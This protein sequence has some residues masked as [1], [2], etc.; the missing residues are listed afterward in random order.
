MHA[1]L[2]KVC[3]LLAL[4]GEMSNMFFSKLEGV[5]S[6]LI[7]A[8]LIVSI[9]NTYLSPSAVNIEK[10]SLNQ[11][12]L[13]FAEMKCPRDDAVY[14]LWDTWETVIQCTTLKS[15]AVY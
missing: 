11:Q 5:P 3:N 13:V 4:S 2:F 8:K 9:C 12:P 14:S 1:F 15:Q 10:G 6:Q 7:S